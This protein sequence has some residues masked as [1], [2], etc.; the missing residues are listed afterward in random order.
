M[1]KSGV[2]LWGLVIGAAA[3]ALAGIL[4]APDKGSATREKMKKKVEDLKDK[5]DETFKA[6]EEVLGQF[7]ESVDEDETFKQKEN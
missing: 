7:E 6:G 4:L 1:K 5:L 3:G 2:F